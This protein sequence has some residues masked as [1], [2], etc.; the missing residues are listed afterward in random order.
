MGIRDRDW[1]WKA[2]DADQG[3]RRRT[4][5]KQSQGYGLVVITLAVI[6]GITVAWLI[7]FNLDR[8]RDHTA[9]AELVRGTQVAIQNA[10]HKQN[11][12]Q[13]RQAQ[14][15]RALEQERR[16]RL[17]AIAGLRRQEAD[18]KRTLVAEEER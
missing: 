15:D 13:E 14:H 10:H 5:P 12:A 8:W 11:L 18:A 17:I 3:S 6:S 16:N 2:R 1:Y 4:G 9:A 7:G